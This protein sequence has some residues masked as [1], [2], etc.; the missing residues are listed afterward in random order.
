M[1]K[2]S[3][4]LFPGDKNN[5]NDEKSFTILTLPHPS[6]QS[7]LATIID[8]TLYELQ[9]AK[10]ARNC[11]FFLNQRISSSKNVYFLTKLDI[12]FIILPFLEKF[13][14]KFSPLDQIVTNLP[15]YS[16]IPLHL[17]TPQM[18]ESICDV[19]DK[20][21]PDMIFY[22]YSSEKTIQWLKSKVEKVSHVVKAQRLLSASTQS[23]SYSSSF[24]TSSD[25]SN[26]LPDVQG[27][28]S[29][30]VCALLLRKDCM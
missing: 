12:R 4:V 22:R 13:G 27:K 29:R 7:T 21:G 23:L 30:I 18:M 9:F 10:Y 5:A 17:V 19:N 24:R 26:S 14:T 20:L 15:G 2:H 11:C 28:L 3:L 1:E 25:H 16:S 6:N 8:N